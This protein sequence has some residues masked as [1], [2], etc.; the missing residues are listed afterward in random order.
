MLT[1]DQRKFGM[2]FLRRLDDRRVERGKALLEEQGK[3]PKPPDD[4]FGVP[5][6]PKTDSN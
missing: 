6:F 5:H 4:D 1:P 3:R 2:Q